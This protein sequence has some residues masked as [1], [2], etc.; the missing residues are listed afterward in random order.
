MDAPPAP[1]RRIPPPPPQRNYIHKLSDNSI[2]RKMPALDI[3]KIDIWHGN[4]ILN[5]EHKKDISEN[6]KGGIQSLDLKPYHLVSYV[7]E[8]GLK[9]YIVDGQHRVSILKDAARKN[10]EQLNFDVIVIEKMCESENEV[11]EYFKLL[12]TTKAIEWKE[13]PTLQ[14]NAYIAAF[15]KEFNK[16]KV[17]LLRS[18]GSHRP[19]MCTK[20]LR[21]AIV[22][23]NL[24][25]LGKTPQEFVEHAL[26]KNK[27]FIDHF[28]SMT[29]R[30]KLHDRALALGFCL[31]IDEK[32][33]W[34]Q[35]FA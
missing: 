1:L 33:S 6:L 2:L 22:K 35:G 24:C 9:T 7:V 10:M 3:V 26:Q 20:K 13:D 30:E 23:S 31:A 21:D 32:F 28:K 25:S 11:I 18:E 5:E 29:L 14:A 15:E 12:N 16:G 17:K 4:R 27:Q 34:F 19:Y 8:D